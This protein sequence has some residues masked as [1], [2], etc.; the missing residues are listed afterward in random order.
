MITVKG[1][2]NRSIRE[3]A[4]PSISKSGECWM[5]KESDNRSDGIEPSTQMLK[6]FC[7]TE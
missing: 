6:A 7:S 3:L 2:I 1:I 5:Q 4:V